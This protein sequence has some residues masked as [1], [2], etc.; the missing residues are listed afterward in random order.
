MIERLESQLRENSWLWEMLRRFDVV[1]LPDGWI[2]AGCI[3]QT[4]WN[5]AC[6]RPAGSGIKDVDLVYFDPTELSVERRPIT[7]DG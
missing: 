3:A 2:V 5:L 1:G 6:G 4:V 7:R